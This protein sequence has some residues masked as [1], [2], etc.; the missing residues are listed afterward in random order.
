LFGQVNTADRA[1]LQF[2]AHLVA[3]MQKFRQHIS[4]A[5]FPKD[6]PVSKRFRPSSVDWGG[7]TAKTHGSMSDGVRALPIACAGMPRN[8]SR[9]E[10]DWQGIAQGD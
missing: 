1:D 6:E 2:G 10:H 4:L 9:G 7:P 5:A 3:Q 8:W